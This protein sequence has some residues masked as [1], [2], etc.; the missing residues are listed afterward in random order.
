ME[1]FSKDRF[2]RHWCERIRDTISGI[3]VKKTSTSFNLANIYQINTKVGISYPVATNASS[4]RCAAGIASGRHLGHVLRRFAAEVHRRNSKTTTCTF[5]EYRWSFISHF[6]TDQNRFIECHVAQ[7]SDSTSDFQGATA[8]QQRPAARGSLFR[9]NISG[10]FFIKRQ[11]VY[12]R[13]R[14]IYRGRIGYGRGTFESNRLGAQPTLFLS[15]FMLTTFWLSFVMYLGTRCA[16]VA[17]ADCSCRHPTAHA[18]PMV[19]YARKKSPAL[20]TRPYGNEGRHRR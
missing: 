13:M 2:K 10:M 6:H 20:T 19:Q 8:G 16:C 12:N 4:S 17:T 11:Q 14:K 7:H 9:P 18:W 1:Q 3:Y 15:P 5:G